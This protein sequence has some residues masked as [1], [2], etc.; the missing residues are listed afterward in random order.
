MT[1]KETF[2]DLIRLNEKSMYH[3]A[4]SIVKNDSDASEVLSESIFRAYKNL[5]KLKSTDVFKAWILKIVHNTAIEFIR[6]N[7]KLISLAEPEIIKDDTEKHLS[8]VISL[9]EAIKQ[10]KQPY[11]T[12]V[13]LYYFEDFSVSQISQITETNVVAVKQQLSRARKQLREI[14]KEDFPNG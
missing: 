8:N 12:V 3:L 9:H 14:L 2:C 5:D 1:D 11:R 10:L 6:K 7:S 13:V 4:F